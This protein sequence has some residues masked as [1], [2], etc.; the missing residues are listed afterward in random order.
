MGGIGVGEGD[1]G[2]THG[3]TWTNYDGIKLQFK[4]VLWIYTKIRI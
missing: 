3:A 2:V 4:N 1:E